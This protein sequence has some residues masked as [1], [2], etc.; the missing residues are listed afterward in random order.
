MT[1]R[2]VVRRGRL[3]AACLVA[4]GAVVLLLLTTRTVTSPDLVGLQALSP[5]AVPALVVALVLAVVPLGGWSRRVLVVPSVLAVVAALVVASVRVAPRWVAQGVPTSD[6]TTLRVMTANLRLGLADPAAVLAAVRREKPDLVAFEEITPGLQRAL[7]AGGLRRQLPYV[8]GRAEPGATGTLVYAVDRLTSVTSLG[9]VHDSWSVEFRGLRVW[10]VHPAYPYDSA[11]LR[12]QERLATA[13]G[14]QRPDVAVGDFNA[15]LDHPPF[16]RI[17]DR[18]LTDAAEQAG[19]G[20]QPTW[21]SDGSKGFPVPVTAIDHVLVGRGITAVGTRV[22]TI[23]GTDH[24]M[25]VAVLALPPG[26]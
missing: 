19:E 23:P 1:P 3:V 6:A 4:L 16:R 25:L 12:D 14:E 13:A 22:H 18:G 15:T 7:E 8:A 9:L 26:P 17:L 10:G 24:L 5:A 20:W 21:P 2:D 11:W